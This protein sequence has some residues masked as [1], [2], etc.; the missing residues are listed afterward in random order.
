MVEKT[1]TAMMADENDRQRHDAV[2]NNPTA[3]L[4]I[5]TNIEMD[6]NT[7]LTNAGGARGV[8]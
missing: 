2:R 5:G 3:S 8:R 6:R 4:R 7:T 1:N